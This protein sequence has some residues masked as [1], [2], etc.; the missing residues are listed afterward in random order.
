VVADPNDSSTVYV[1]FGGYGAGAHV[2]MS[3]DDGATWTDVTGNLPNAP[4]YSMAVDPIVDEWFVGGVDAVWRT[5]DNGATWMPLGMLPAVPVF[6]L[7]IRE[8]NPRKLVAGTY[9]RGIWEL[10]LSSGGG[11]GVDDPEPTRGVRHLMLDP[12]A[13]NP[14]RDGT[15]IRFAARFPGD[16]SLQVFDVAGRRVSDLATVRGDGRVRLVSW[17]PADVPPG[18]YFVVLRAGEERVS[19]KVIVVR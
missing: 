14:V 1:T 13:P 5:I 16:V 10:G 17:T 12:P 11:V 18:T 4:I 3:E 15:T 9:G 6:D 2:A 8:S 19:R 7:E